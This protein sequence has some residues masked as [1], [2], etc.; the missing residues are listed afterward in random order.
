MIRYTASASSRS[1]WAAIARQCLAA[2]MKK[3]A[4]VSSLALATILSHNSAFERISSA[5]SI[6]AVPTEPDAHFAEQG[7]SYLLTRTLGLKYERCRPAGGNRWEIA[8]LSRTQQ[9]G[10]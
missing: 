7:H 6:I 5:R 8:D 9:S 10:T 1:N 2:W 4:I 3:N